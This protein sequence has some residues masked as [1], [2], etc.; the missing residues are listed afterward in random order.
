MEKI[1]SKICM[2]LRR[3]GCLPPGQSSTKGRLLFL[4]SIY[5]I[6]QAHV[7]IVQKWNLFEQRITAME[8]INIFYAFFFAITDYYL[9]PQHLKT[10]MEVIKFPH[11][12]YDKR[13]HQPDL[14]AECSDMIRHT[15]RTWSK[16]GIILEIAMKC[17]FFSS[18]ILPVIGFIQ[19]TMGYESENDLTLPF[20]SYFS[21]GKNNLKSYI[22]ILLVEMIYIYYAFILAILL[23]LMTIASVHNVILEMRLFCMCL[24]GFNEN[25]LKRIGSICD[26]NKDPKR[27]GGDEIRDEI[28]ILKLLSKELSE[29]HQ[30]IYRKVYMLKKGFK[31]QLCYGNG[32]ICFQLCFA[33]FCFLKDDLMFK[34]KY[35]TVTF[36][37]ALLLLIFSESGQEIQRQVL[38]SVYSYFN[39]LRQFSGDL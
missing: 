15:K 17:F 5:F 22:F 25:Y 28:L 26:A 7:I 38:R 35:G 2:Y 30:L 31:F 16:T 11:Y 39:F 21:V 4:M 32:V 20:V 33:T 27:S 19:H 18:N 37:V 29:H 23:Y 10:M 9:F 14:A 34:L 13:L 24:Q 3:L 36:L 6:L 1:I 8:N 12:K